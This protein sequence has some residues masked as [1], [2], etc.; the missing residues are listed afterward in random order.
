MLPLLIYN[1]RIITENALIT[2]GWLLCDNGVI[3]AYGEGTPPSLEGAHNTL[4][5]EG[6]WLAPGFI[7]VHVHG[8]M[9]AEL[10][11]GT[12]AALATMG[13]FYAQHGVTGYLPT[14][15]S[16]T[17]DDLMRALRAVATYTRGRHEAQILGVHLE[18]PYLNV[19]KCGAQKPEHIRLA[20]R[21]EARTLLDVGVIRLLSLAPEFEANQWLIGECVARGVTASIAHTNATYEQALHAFALGI[22][23]STHTFNAM[24]GLNHR[25]P[26]VVGAV[27]GDGRVR[28]ELIADLV[29]VHEGA[30]RALFAAKGTSGLILI[31]DAMR[32]SGMPDGQYRLGEHTV[33]V[34]DGTA[35]LA[36]G[37]LAGSVATYSACVRNFVRVVG[38]PFADLWQV[39][40]L[41]PA[42][43]IGIADR[44]G[45]IAQGK[46]ADLVLL[47][48]ALN[49]R[50]TVIL[51]ELL[52][53]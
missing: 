46:D 47:D 41:T 37:T 32:A 13:A 44:K 14:T 50:A 30:I 6:A 29:H 33:N 43:A 1:A 23:H 7:D 26:G 9:N 15:L 24:T 40:S 45:S 53:R 36:D 35:T 11:D 21:D 49:V 4:N 19:A 10:M 51:G 16:G 3:R 48:D 18:G 17:H 22:T 5:A 25:L 20:D 38:K 31:T 39:T 34:A 27:M 52:P 8:A 42:Q 12:H 28:C 2:R